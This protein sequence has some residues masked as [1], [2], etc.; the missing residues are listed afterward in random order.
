MPKIKTLCC[1]AVPIRKG[2]ADY[3]CSICGKDVTLELYFIYESQSKKESNNKRQGSE[4]K[5]L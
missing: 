3:R 4:K 1:N 2:R 5:G